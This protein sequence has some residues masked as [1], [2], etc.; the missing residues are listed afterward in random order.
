M[1]LSG[2]AAAG[3]DHPVTPDTSGIWSR[4]NQDILRYGVI[5]TEIGGA[6]WLGGEDPLG[7]TFWES[8][9]ASAFG[10]ATAEIAKHVFG[11]ARP[12]QTS[13][14]NEWFKGS[15]CHSFP[16]G[17]VTLQASFVT[18]FIVNY[19]RDNPWVWA[20]EALPAYDAVARVKSGAHWQTDVIAGWALGTGFGYWAAKRNSPLFLQIMPQGVAV[21]LHTRF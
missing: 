5:A 20:L 11:R 14:P 19:A 9:D 10:S 21:G 18:P 16:S 13:D 4:T 3:I 12:S 7:R 2:I 15:C 6:L 17:E 1:G 8:I